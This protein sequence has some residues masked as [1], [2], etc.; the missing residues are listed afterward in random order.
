MVRK[1][2]TFIGAFLLVGV[3]VLTAWVTAP[4]ALPKNT[5]T[6]ALAATGSSWL[7]TTSQSSTQA[8]DLLTQLGVSNSGLLPSDVTNSLTTVLN[9]GQTNGSYPYWL[10]VTA[11][12]LQDDPTKTLGTVVVG[13]LTDSSIVFPIALTL[14]VLI[15]FWSALGAFA[16]F[17]LT[18]I[19]LIT[20]LYMFV[21][22]TVAVTISVVGLFLLDTFVYTRIGSTELSVTQLL[23]LSTG[24]LIAILVASILLWYP[25]FPYL[26][27]L[28]SHF[29]IV[30]K[31]PRGSKNQYKFL[32]SLASIILVFVAALLYPWQLTGPSIAAGIALLL[33][34]F[35]LPKTIRDI[36]VCNS[37]LPTTKSTPL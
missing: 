18:F 37:L 4:E 36:R 26:A 34:L 15:F 28:L 30:E 11:G 7:T 6:N 2:L 25:F 33:T 31:L 21:Y 12:A 23:L 1:V 14:L 5:Q 13:I 16:S 22:R 17:G 9:F 32:L 8:S 29:T 3:V 20:F 19:S 10:Q 24:F 35:V 27:K